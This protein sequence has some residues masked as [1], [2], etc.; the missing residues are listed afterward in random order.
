M[1]ENRENTF[2]FGMTPQVSVGWRSET[3]PEPPPRAAA[4]SPLALQRQGLRGKAEGRGFLQP[5]PVT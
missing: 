1:V 3:A 2:S 5:A 4:P